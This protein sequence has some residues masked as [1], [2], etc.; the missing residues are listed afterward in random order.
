LPEQ[1]IRIGEN[2]RRADRAIWVG[3]GRTIRPDQDVP[4]IAVEFVSRS[5]R[6]RQ[7]DYVEKRREYAQAGVKEYWVI[8]RFAREMTVFRGAEETLNVP[9]GEVYRT[10][11]LPGFELPLDRLLARADQYQAEDE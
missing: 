5:S 8:D 4:T 10:P 3:H 11:L 1:E 7:R 6:D 9:E 2:R